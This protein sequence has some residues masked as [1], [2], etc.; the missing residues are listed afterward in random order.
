MEREMESGRKLK[1]LK[2]DEPIPGIN[3]D[4]DRKIFSVII[5]VAG[6]DDPSWPPVTKEQVDNIR[7]AIYKD[8][9]DKNKT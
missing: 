8:I 3:P 6:P 1:L 4:K 5:P 2:E 9:L 7:E